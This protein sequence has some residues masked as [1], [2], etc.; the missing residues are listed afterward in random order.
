MMHHFPPELT[1]VVPTFEERGNI[2]P[3]VA[4]LSEA[5]AGIEWDVIFVDDAS[6]DGTGAEVLR[7]GATDPRVKL[8]SRVG[9]RGLSGAC[10]EGML[11]AVAPL[12]AVMDADLQHDE[13]KLA[14]M[15][16]LLRAEPGLSLVIGSRS[17]A[18]GAAIGGLS[19]LRHWGSRHANGLARRA[20]GLRVS[21]PM[22]GF[23]ML[24]RS[25]LTEIACGLQ[26]QGFKILADMLAVAG[27]RWTVR[28]LAYS[29]RPRLS[30]RSKMNATVAF[31]LGGLVLSR[32]TGGL[33][34]LRFV[35]F[36][37][38]GT[39]GLFTQLAMLRLALMVSPGHFP[40]AQAIGVIA[41]MTSNFL[42][43]NAI[44]WR[45]RRLQGPALLRGLASFYLVCGI[46]ALG[47]ILAAASLFHLLPIWW[48]ASGIGAL[49]GA[50][51]NFWASV[52]VTWQR[53]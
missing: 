28:E 19:K 42:L 25:A 36:C 53:S 3:L 39:L 34:P 35:L 37:F 50:V 27:K 18:G 6:A 1:V 2:A 24:R 4:R 48:L 10:I 43:N 41:A 22:S 11:S 16:A 9:R 7:I 44:T 20:L 26:P 52:T 30:G 5:L 23:F 45:E 32:L 29:F 13:P 14:E 46:G 38:V 47:N 31:E 49:A 8:L 40:A 21:D 51:W 15:V 33:L 17:I 12:V